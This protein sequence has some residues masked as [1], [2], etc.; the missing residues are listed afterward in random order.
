MVALPTHWLDARLTRPELLSGTVMRDQPLARLLA[1]NLADGYAMAGALSPAAATL[2]ARHAI[3]LLAK[4]LKERQHPQPRP[5]EARRA[6]VFPRACR[7]IALEFGDAALTPERLASRLGVATGTLDQI[8]AD[9]GESAMQ[10]IYG[11]RVGQATRLLTEAAAAHR[12]VTEIAFACGFNDAS[13]FGRAFS[14]RKHLTPAQWR[15]RG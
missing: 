12:S 6:A 3:D 15:W 11:E 7:S 13:H 5:S 14:A 10:R 4:A 1:R 2:F 8:F 9:Q